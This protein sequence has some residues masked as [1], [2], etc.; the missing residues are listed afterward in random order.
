[1]NIHSDYDSIHEHVYSAEIPTYGCQ[2]LCTRIFVAE[3]FRIAQM[4]NNPKAFGGG[5]QEEMP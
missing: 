1:M 3:L 5:G 4:E 2:R